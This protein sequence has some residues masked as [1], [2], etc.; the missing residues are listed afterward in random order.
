MFEMLSKQIA[1]R[2]F[3]L[4]EDGIAEINKRYNM[5][6]LTNTEKEDLLAFLEWQYVL[7]DEIF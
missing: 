7:E 5:G 6:L 3:N 4:Y 2:T 1:N